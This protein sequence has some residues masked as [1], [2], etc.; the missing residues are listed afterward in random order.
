MI[1]ILLLLPLIGLIKF[2]VDR[3]AEKD[4][5]RARQKSAKRRFI[6]SRGGQA[7]VDANT[8]EIV[9]Y[10]Q[11]PDVIAG[12]Y[13]TDSHRALLSELEKDL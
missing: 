1:E 12:S 6:Q 11:D 5:K 2:L 13:Y 7:V 8:G 4:A 9:Y 3:R 10:I